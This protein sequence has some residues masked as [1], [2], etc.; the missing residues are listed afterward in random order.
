MVDL[1]WGVSRDS[2][3]NLPELLYCSNQQFLRHRKVSREVNRKEG[4]MGGH[5]LDL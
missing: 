2:T 3:L 1:V 5:N 4:M